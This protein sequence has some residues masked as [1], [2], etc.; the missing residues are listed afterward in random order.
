MN[1][2]SRNPYYNQ[3]GYPDPTAYNAL[4]PIIKDDTAIKCEKNFLIK[5]LKYIISNAGFELISRIELR[6]KAS[7]REFR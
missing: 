6:D 4:K 2:G 3:S 5:V 1:R 7:G